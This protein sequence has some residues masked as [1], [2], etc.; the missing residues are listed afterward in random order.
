MVKV[1]PIKGIKTD[2]EQQNNKNNIFI[3]FNMINYRIV[4]QLTK[5]IFQ[6][7]YIVGTTNIE[8]K[9]KEREFSIP[10]IT[11]HR[12]IQIKRKESLDTTPM[13]TF[14]LSIHS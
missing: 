6:N 1:W 11:E 12:L 7:E 8:I 9:R 3:K 14:Y 10:S 4:V 2:Y 13:Y 5:L